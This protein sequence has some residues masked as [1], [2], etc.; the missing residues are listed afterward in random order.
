MIGGVM[1][2][3]DERQ[4]FKAMTLFLNEFYS[5]AGNDME[6]LLADIG[7]EADGQPLDPAAW[8]DWLQCVEE[9]RRESAT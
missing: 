3:I 6:T 4:A 7:L 9:A 1:A 2:T 5:R 8:N